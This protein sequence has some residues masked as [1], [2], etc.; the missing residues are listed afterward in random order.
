M[1]LTKKISSRKFI[2]MWLLQVVTTTLL[3]F[4]HIDMSIWAGM[5]I[6]IFGS[7]LGANVSQHIWG[8]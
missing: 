4:S 3:I 8:K 5:T 7:Y 2:S 6:L 1:E